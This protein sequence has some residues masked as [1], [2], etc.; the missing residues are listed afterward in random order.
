MKIFPFALYLCL[1]TF[2]TLHAQN[3]PITFA[4]KVWAGDFVCEPATLQCAGFE[5]EIHGDANRDAQVAVSYRKLG[6]AQWTPAQPL[7]RIGGEKI[8]GHG[9]RWIYETP[10]MFA[11]SIFNLEED[12]DYEC[13]FI[14]SDP[15]GVLGEDTLVQRVIHTRKEP[16]PYSHGNIYH[17]YPID[18]EGNKIQPAFTGLNEAYYGGGN[19]GDWWLVPEPRVQPGDIILIHAGTYKGDLLNYVD[20]L[21]L[22]FHGAYVLTQKATADKPITIKAAGDGEV[23]F[24]GSG[25]YR[26]FDVMAADYH[27]FEGLTIRNTQI[28]F[29]AGLKHVKGCSGLTVKH[30]QI[31]DVGI[32]VM[33]HSEES[34]NFYIADNTMI[35]RHDPDTL[36]GW[37]GFEE[38][39]PLSSYYAIKVYGSGHVICHNDISFFHDGICVD[40][41]G[42]PEDSQQQKCVSID[43]YRNDIFNMSDDFIETDGGVH[44]IRV[45]EN[46]GFNS[47]HAGLSAQPMFGGP[48]Y[49][50]RNTLY[51]VTGTTLKFT[52]RPA[53]L[54]VYQN[55]FCTNTAFVS[56]ANTHFRNNLFMSTDAERAWSGTFLTDYSSSDYNGYCVLQKGFRWRM[57]NNPEYNNGDEN[58]LQWQDAT[59]LKTFQKL[60]GWETHGV[61][62][63]YSIFKNVAPPDPQKKG[64]V[65]PREGYD[66]QLVQGAKAIDQGLL[67]PN[68]ND[69][70]TGQAPD[71]G[72]WEFGTKEINYGRRN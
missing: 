19:G 64:T 32:A 35:G 68:I 27:Y 36:H 21:A 24:D 66:F 49:F 13:R 26:L 33:T 65:Y 34:K 54:L 62:L 39:T 43:I 7:L 3:N 22:N 67:L 16:E 15:D 47:Y 60:T 5:W 1:S 50:I 20:P 25:A 14:M 11:G 29:Y 55:T 51:Q 40:T 28:A 48:A 9:Q 70:Y 23:I 4:D 41:H 12:T 71:L 57:P 58:E 8:Y 56:A 69:Q 52:I 59:D 30:C 6:V 31:E 17:V 42:L 53:G 45:F 37:Y 46:R 10:P 2:T 38:P 63:N 61:L 18:Y 72:A 44:N